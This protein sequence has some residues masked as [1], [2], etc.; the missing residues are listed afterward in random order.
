MKKLTCVLLI[1]FMIMSTCECV[2]AQ[3]SDTLYEYLFLDKSYNIT[4][5]ERDETRYY[6]FSPDES[7]YY[8]LFSSDLSYEDPFVYCYDE[9]HNEIGF[10]DDS[11][12]RKNFSY[13]AYMEKGRKYYFEV[14][15][16]Y[17]TSSMMFHIE[18]T[19]LDGTSEE[20]FDD[21]TATLVNVDNKKCT[22]LFS[23]TPKEDGYYAFYS[24]SFADTYAILLDSQFKCIGKDDDSGENEN[25]YLSCYLLASNTYYFMVM[26]SHLGIKR[27]FDVFL[28]KAEV[29]TDISFVSYPDKMTYYEGYVE[30]TVNLSGLVIDFIYS[31]GSTLR[32]DYDENEE[33]I[34]ATV[35]IKPKKDDDG[36]YYFYVMADYAYDEFYVD[37]IENPI[38]S[39]S[40]HSGSKLTLEQYMKG[41]WYFNSDLNKMAFYYYYSLPSDL[42]IEIKYS[43]GT[44]AYAKF[45]EKFDDMYF[46]SSSD[47]RKSEW[48]LGENP[49]TIMYYGKECVFNA[50]VVDNGIKYLSVDSEPKRKYIHVPMWEEQLYDTVVPYD[51]TGLVLTAHYK[52]GAQK[53]YT[54]KDVY[55]W[56]STID[57]IPYYVE[58][59][60]IN[61]AGKYK[62]AMGFCGHKVS[63]DVHVLC[64]GDADSDNELTVMDATKIQMYLVSSAWLSEDETNVSD[65]NFDGVVTVIDATAVQ[66]FLAHISMF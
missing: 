57:D 64:L 36:K 37:V 13:N 41:Q 19:R 39:I 54:D 26:D 2:Y 23:F 3:K 62:T 22:A 48:K 7:G 11:G 45:I 38:E 20:I 40:V 14:G 30:E 21:D 9:N 49:I 65:V 1:V 29:I 59:F 16:R 60:R 46:T 4:F 24:D 12:M 47:Q 8:S 42:V 27:S 15:A 66:R 5:D 61:G 31:D 50:E 51:L 28:K 6:M 18:I 55:N 34:G 58:S 35:E 33:I 52:D 44:S 10:D 63:Y 32:W 43:D 53:T 56:D 17:D 25:C